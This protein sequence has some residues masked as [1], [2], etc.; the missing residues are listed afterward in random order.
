MYRNEQYF[1]QKSKTTSQA[2][3]VQCNI[4][5]RSCN[6]C[7]SGTAI[8]ITYSEFVC[9]FRYPAYCQLSSVGCPAVQYFTTSSHK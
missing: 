1:E 2:L 4:E 9:S 7:C 5:G 6:Y 3:Y 8:S